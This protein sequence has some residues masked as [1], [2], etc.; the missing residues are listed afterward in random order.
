[1]GGTFSAS[2]VAAEGRVYVVSDAG[3]T[4]VLEL[5]P[6]MKITG[7][8]ALG[9]KVQAS[10]AISHGQIFIRTEKNLYAIGAK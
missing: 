9:E 8:N 6:E 5:G 7:K 2:P 10:P 4:T 1:L 3:E